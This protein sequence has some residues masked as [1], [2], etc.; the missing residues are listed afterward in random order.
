M[1]RYGQ[2]SWLGSLVDL[3]TVVDELKL[4]QLARSKTM[5][6]ALA[7]TF[8]LLWALAMVSSYT[9]GGFVHV[10]I[11]AAVLAV[12]YQVIRNRRENT[13]KRGV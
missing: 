5:V 4:G 10:F 11:V 1:M 9:F 8:G 3:E 7:I 12:V 6:W 13:F 2:A